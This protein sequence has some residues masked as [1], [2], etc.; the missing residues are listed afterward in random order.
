[1]KRL[2]TRAMT[3]ELDR[4]AGDEAEKHRHSAEVGDRLAVDLALG[5]WEIDDAV[6]DGVVAPDDVVAVDVGGAAVALLLDA[7]D[8]ALLGQRR[9]D[10]AEV[11]AIFLQTIKQHAL[12]FE[13]RTF[14]AGV[15]LANNKDYE[16]PV[17]SSEDYVVNYKG[18]QEI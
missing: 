13:A 2:H 15:G 1:M 16:L 10:P 14:Y 4:Q 17:D 9:D 7:D 3:R 6:G 11:D 5:I 8:L 18:L 12:K